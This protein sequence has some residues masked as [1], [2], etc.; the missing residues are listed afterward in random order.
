MSGR[1]HVNTTDSAGR[2]PNIPSVIVVTCQEEKSQHKNRA[3]A[4]KVLLARLYEHEQEEQDAQRAASRKNQIGSGDRSARIRTYHFPQ[5][6]VTYHRI[7][8]T[9]PKLERVIHGAALGEVIAAIGR[10]RV[11]N[12]CVSTCRSRW[13]PY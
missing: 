11:G 9:L 13:W 6:R 7:N 1:Q 3:K 12:E 5:G 8:L 10:A 4:M 2:I